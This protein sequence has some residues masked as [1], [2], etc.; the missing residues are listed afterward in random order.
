[1]GSRRVLSRRLRSLKCSKLYSGEHGISIL[2]WIVVAVLA[3]DTFS[4]ADEPLNVVRAGEGRATIT[5]ADEAVLAAG[6][7]LQSFLLKITGAKVPIRSWS[8]T[9]PSSSRIV[10]QPRPVR[11]V[12]RSGKNIRGRN[13][14]LSDGSI[15]ISSL[16]GMTQ[17][18]FRGLDTQPIDFWRNS[19]AS[20]SVRI[21]SGTLLRDGMKLS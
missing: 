6:R 18:H 15:V 20:A 8:E 5:H 3:G 16:L 21:R 7:R 9:K 13:E 12:S 17:A 2:I 10:I 11:L 1:M 14:L 4:V 19:I